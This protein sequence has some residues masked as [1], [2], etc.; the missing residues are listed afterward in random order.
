MAIVNLLTRLL[1]IRNDDDRNNYT[2]NEEKIREVFE[3]DRC[4]SWIKD[5][6]LR[7]VTL[8]FPDNLLHYAPI[9]TRHIEKEI[10]GQR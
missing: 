6:S 1:F 3:V 9:I 5:N 8:Q 4:A 10:G 7:N 2:I